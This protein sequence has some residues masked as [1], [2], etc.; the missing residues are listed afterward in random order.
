MGCQLKLLLLKLEQAGA[1]IHA[2]EL[3][4]MLLMKP[5]LVPKSS[6]KAIQC[7]T[8]ID[9]FANHCP[10]SSSDWQPSPIP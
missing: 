4:T 5:F 6:D 8:I 1:T 7:L 3:V 2:A 10:S 9:F